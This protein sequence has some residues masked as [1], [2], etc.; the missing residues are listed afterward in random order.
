MNN[1]L[2]T[3]IFGTALGNIGARSFSVRGS[4]RSV[5]TATTSGQNTAV[6]PLAFSGTIKKSFPFFL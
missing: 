4:L 2:L 6:R 1:L 5:G 3:P